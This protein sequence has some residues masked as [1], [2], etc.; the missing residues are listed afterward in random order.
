MKRPLVFV[1]LALASRGLLPAASP[2]AEDLAFFER[3]VRPVL[4]ARCEAADVAGL[5][6]LKRALAEQLQASGLT[7]PL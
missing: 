5:E 7:A 3:N 4:V 6:R 1:L 2:S